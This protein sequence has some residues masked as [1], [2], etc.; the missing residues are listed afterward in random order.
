MKDLFK[1][2]G[3]EYYGI[4][5]YIVGINY[6]VWFLEVKKDGLDLYLEIKRRVKEK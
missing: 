4:E 3:M 5:E 1:F 6:M 2:F